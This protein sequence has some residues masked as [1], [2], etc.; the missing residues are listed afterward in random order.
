MIK[1]LQTVVYEVPD[2]DAAR[3]F[4]SKLFR[5]E[6]YFDQPFYIGFSIAGFELGLHPEHP[7]TERVRNVVAHWSVDDIRAELDYWLSCGAE[8]VDDVYSAGGD[9]QAAAVRDPFGNVIGLISDPTFSVVLTSAQGG[10]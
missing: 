10:H 5:C 3:V 4:Y 2:M 8:L 6:P 1:G 9:I 7:T